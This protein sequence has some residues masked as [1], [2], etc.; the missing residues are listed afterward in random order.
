MTALEHIVA[1][2]ARIKARVVS[3]DEREAG[4]R[5]I[6]NYGHT[7]GHAI[8]TVTGYGRLHHGE[9]IAIGME[10][11]ARLSARLGLC[12]PS[13]VD[14]QRRLLERI[15]LPTELPPRIDP[16]RL[17]AAMALDKKVKGGQ[18]HFILPE[19]R[20]G[21]VVVQPVGSDLVKET[22]AAFA[23]RQSPRRF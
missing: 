14:R 17:L 23:R 21:R 7:L 19:E 16:A 8:E 18:C 15:G 11:A 5:R 20:I 1:R 2:S 9:A 22:L 6:L 10:F 3:K 4:L 13:L 12:G